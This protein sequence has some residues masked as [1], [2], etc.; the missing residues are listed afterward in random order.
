MENKVTERIT[1]KMAQMDTIRRYQLLPEKKYRLKLLIILI[2]DIL[3]VLNHLSLIPRYDYGVI[4]YSI[5]DY[6]VMILI[7]TILAIIVLVSFLILTNLGK[8]I[9]GILG[10]IKKI[11]NALN[12]F[13]SGGKNYKKDYGPRVG[14]GYDAY[15]R[16][17]KEDKEKK[18][19]QGKSEPF[20]YFREN[21][22]LG[23]SLRDYGNMLHYIAYFIMWTSLTNISITDYE[24]YTIQIVV[25]TILLILLKKEPE[26]T[27]VIAKYRLKD[28]FDYYCSPHG[29]P[30]LS[31]AEKEI[32]DANFKVSVSNQQTHRRGYWSKGVYNNQEFEY[33]AALRV[34]DLK[35]GFRYKL[36][37]NSDKN[38]Q[39]WDR[40]SGVEIVTQRGIKQG[41]GRSRRE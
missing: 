26:N 5:Q 21:T 30:Q 17:V 25:S 32:F 18:K 37:Y 20:L 27:R 29:K 19:K 8:I 38:Y 1:P 6:L 7:Y 24:V 34:E 12:P 39:S 15:D 10:L 4:K 11:L 23:N 31:K 33:W 16:M 36:E 13:H 35:Y 3:L 14:P 9:K 40:V 28:A 2:M 22:M 41:E